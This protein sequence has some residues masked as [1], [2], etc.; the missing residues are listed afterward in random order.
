[1]NKQ[2]RAKI[3]EALHQLNNLKEQIDEMRGE[4]QDYYD[5]MPESLQGGDKGEAAQSAAD[6]LSNAVTEIDSAISS[7]EEIE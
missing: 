6:S 5:N 7:L 2:R 3:D 4:E 1:M